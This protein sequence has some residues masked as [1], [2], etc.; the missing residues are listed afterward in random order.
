MG[1]ARTLV[2]AWYGITGSQ[3]SIEDT[4][5]RVQWLI[6][7]AHYAFGEMDYEVSLIFCRD[8]N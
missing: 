7:D 5:S 1:K 2:G 4:A 3:R 8:I 6:Q